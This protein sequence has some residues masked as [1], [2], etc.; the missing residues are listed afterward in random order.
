MPS[1]LLSSIALYLGKPSYYS[2]KEIYCDLLS[3][4]CTSKAGEEA[5][6]RAAKD[7]KSCRSLSFSCS[8][9]K[10]TSGRSI[11]TMSRIFGGRLTH[12]GYSGRQNGPFPTDIIRPLQD[13]VLRTQ[14]RLV[15]LHISASA[16]SV[17]A[18]L[19]MCR[20]SPLLTSL[21][22]AHF[23]GVEAFTSANILRLA[24]G[25][26]KLVDLCWHL[27][28]LTPLT[29]GAGQDVDDLEELLESRA[30]QRNEDTYF[31]IDVFEEYGP[32]KPSSYHYENYPTSQHPTGP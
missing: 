10:Q 17:T 21:S 24:R 15:G 14:G 3:L 27:D 32:W 2:K 20:A 9:D 12:L 11:A 28:G 6:R 30:K 4:R 26:P 29:D 31:E 18:L 25:C 5:V 23:Y 16:I 8:K 22:D 13:A 1:E 7:H 19:D